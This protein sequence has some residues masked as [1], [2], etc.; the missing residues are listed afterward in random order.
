MLRPIGAQGGARVA[1]IEVLQHP[2]HVAA[3]ASLIRAIS[4]IPNH[5]FVPN[6]AVNEVNL[7]VFFLVA[8]PWNSP[9]GTIRNWADFGKYTW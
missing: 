1:S 9:T 4:L 8:L 3:G 2:K 7:W 5:H 6:I